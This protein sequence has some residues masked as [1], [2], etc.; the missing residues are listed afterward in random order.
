MGH[1]P[2]TDQG[3]LQNFLNETGISGFIFMGNNVPADEA[4]LAEL[5]SALRGDP[6]F[7]RLLAIDQEGG[8]VS[9]L[10]W[11]TF[12]GAWSLKYE[13]E[14]ATATAFSGRA[15]LLKE[16]GINLNFGIVADYTSDQTSYIYD[17]VLGVTPQDAASRVHAAVQAE[18]GT[19]AS[20]LKHFPGHG[21]TP[22]DSHW[23]LPE[24]AT[25]YEAWIDAEALPFKAGIAAGAE[26]VMFG[27]LIYS[28]VD[29][30]PASLSSRWHEILRD[31]LGFEGVSVTD[32]MSMLLDSGAGEYADPQSNALMALQAGNDLLLFVAHA[33]ATVIT[34]IIDYLL[35]AVDSGEL[36]EE[37]LTEAALRVAEM[38]LA[39]T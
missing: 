15:Q 36:S 38:R 34:G 8:I 39:A 32:D 22:N 6:E 26:S 29:T 28:D 9:R 25:S 14:G 4:G 35:D 31:D 12:D 30:L 10:H 27:H 17:R 18:K 24:T 19:V 37:R 33:D 7:P 21:A 20:T 11:D 23:G 3:Q 5:T 2:G 13:E 16:A 1:I